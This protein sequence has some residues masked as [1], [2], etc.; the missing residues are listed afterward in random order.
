MI[1]HKG[2]ETNNFMDDDL[3]SDDDLLTFEVFLKY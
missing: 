2:A 1:V 3:I